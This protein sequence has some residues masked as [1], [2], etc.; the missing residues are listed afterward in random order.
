[1]LR[2]LLFILSFMQVFPTYALQ[3]K[4][5][6]DNETVSATASLSDITRIAVKDDRI[7]RLRGNKGAYLHENDEEKGEIF[8]QPAQSKAFTVLLETE[9]GKHFTL[10]LNPLKVPGDTLMLIP[11]GEYDAKMP[12]KN[13][14]GESVL[15]YLVK[16]MHKDILPEGYHMQRKTSQAYLLENLKARLLSV[17]RNGFLQGEVFEVE[18]TSHQ[19]MTLSEQDFF[20]PKTR[21]ISIVSRTLQPQQIT[22]LYRVVQ[23]EK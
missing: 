9:K 21:V 7:K 3:V 18:N 2:A 19:T 23:N 13:Y 5:V 12:E 15:F 1:M 14:I 16:A 4:K 10:L 17:Y 20:K 22:K 8:I 11:Q 6:K